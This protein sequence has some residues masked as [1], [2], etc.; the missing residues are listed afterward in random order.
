MGFPA[1]YIVPLCVLIKKKNKNQQL[2]KMPNWSAPQMFWS[3]SF[4]QGLVKNILMIQLLNWELMNCCI[5]K[6][7]GISAYV[8]VTRKIRTSVM[9]T[10]IKCCPQNVISG[11]KMGCTLRTNEFYCA[12]LAVTINGVNKTRITF[13]ICYNNQSITGECRHKV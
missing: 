3:I 13:Q 10:E 1:Y 4:G 9:V 7:I 6:K 11:S 8:F 5:F 12:F 2:L